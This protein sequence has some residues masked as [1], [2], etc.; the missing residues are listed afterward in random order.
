MKHMDRRSFVK[1]IG[2]AGAG[3]VCTGWPRRA[4]AQSLPPRVVVVGGGFGGATV[5]KYLKVWGGKAVSVTLVDTNPFH[6]SCILSNLVV[7]K[8]MD[9]PDIQMSFASLQSVH[10]VEFVQGRAVAVGTNPMSVTVETAGGSRMLSCDRVV[11]SPGVDFVTPAGSYDPLLTPH[12]WIAGD[13]TQ[14]LRKMLAGMKKKKTFLMNIPK[15]P[16][17]CPPG[18]YERACVVADYIKRKKLGGKVVVLDANPSIQAEPETFSKAFSKTFKGIVD[19]RPGTP[20]TAVDSSGRS[21]VTEAGTFNGAVVNFIPEHKAGRIVFDAGLVDTANGARWAAVDPLSYESL[22]VPGVHVLG[23]SQAT[24]QPKSGTMANSQAK[25][26]ADAIL[27]WIGGNPPDPS[28]TTM[29]ACYSPI[30]SKSASWLTATYQ[31]DGVAKAMVRVAESF[32][33]ADAANSENYVDMFRWA[34]GLFG[35]CYA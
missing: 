26:C 29:S 11:L 12:A 10:G 24:G 30:T 15:A 21:L 33:E 6:Y 28:P 20:V 17:R 13:Q 34:E 14:L 16:Y 19:Y 31:Y 18:P 35:D 5:A 7:A 3:A 4:R 9:L 23:D 1:W 25:V 22:R 27:R 8:V 2:A 32:G